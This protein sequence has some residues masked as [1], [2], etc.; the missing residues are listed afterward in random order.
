MSSRSTSLNVIEPLGERGFESETCSTT[1]GARKERE[2]TAMN[3]PS[4]DS[5]LAGVRVLDLTRLLPGPVA[6]L[7][8]ADL[9]ATVDKVEDPQAGDYARISGPQ[10]DG[11]SGLFHTLGR[12]KR[13][14]V[15]DLK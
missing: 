14:L 15:L 13:S 5:P 12:G 2:V 10:V 3:S 8:L 6:S 1:C 7:I 4:S 9:G 11:H